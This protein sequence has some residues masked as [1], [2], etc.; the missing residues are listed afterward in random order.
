MITMFKH[1]QERKIAVLK[2]I[3]K[4]SYNNKWIAEE[5]NVKPIEINYDKQTLYKHDFIDR[6]FKEQI[7]VLTDKGEFALANGFDVEYQEV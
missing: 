1:T 5:Q 7:W 2:A 3:S 4:C 6:G